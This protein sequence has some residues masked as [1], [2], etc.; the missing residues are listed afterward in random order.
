MMSIVMTIRKTAL[1]IPRQVSVSSLVRLQK[2]RV[3]EV[4]FKEKTRNF[5]F[6][7]EKKKE[8][9]ISFNIHWKAQHSNGLRDRPLI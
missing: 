5:K 9:Q 1:G 2:I 6:L 4:I 8:L 3:D 7:Q